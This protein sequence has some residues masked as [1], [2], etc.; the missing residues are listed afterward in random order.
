MPGIHQTSAFLVYQQGAVLRA[1]FLDDTACGD[2][3]ELY[4]SGLVALG[5][6]LGN[7]A[8]LVQNNGEGKAVWSCEQEV[9]R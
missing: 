8:Q 7:G 6:S 5:S 4:L 3:L 9:Q 2:D 1:A